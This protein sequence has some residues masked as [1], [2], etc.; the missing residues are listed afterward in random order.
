[1]RKAALLLFMVLFP[2]M[3]AEVCAQN[4][5]YD[6]NGDGIVDNEDVVCLVNKILGIADGTDDSG[7]SYDV[8]KDQKIDMVDVTTVIA[9]LSDSA[10]SEVCVLNEGIGDWSQMRVSNKGGLVAVKFQNETV[11][12]PNQVALLIPNSNGGTSHVAFLNFQDDGTLRSVLVDENMI[13]IHSS[14]DGMMDVTVVLGDTLALCY[15]RIP[16]SSAMAR[17]LSL[18]RRAWGENNWVSNVHGALDMILGVAETLLGG[19]IVNTSVVFSG[20]GGAGLGINTG[21]ATIE[22]GLSNIKE[23]YNSL[24]VES[25][26]ESDFYFGERI[27]GKLKEK[28]IDVIGSDFIE[29]I[30]G[31]SRVANVVGWIDFV[32]DYANEKWGMTMTANDFDERIQGRVSTMPPTVHQESAIISAYIDPDLAVS[33]LNG[34]PLNCECGFAIFPANNK[35]SYKLYHLGECSGG[36][37]SV[38]AAGLTPG[39]RYAYRA[40]FKDIDHS[41]TAWSWDTRAFITLKVTTGD[42]KLKLDESFELNGSVI[43]TENAKREARIWF[44]YSAEN[45]DPH[46]GYSNCT[47]ILVTENAHDGDYSARLTDYNTDETYYYRIVL[48][49]DGVDNNGEVRTF[50]L[51]RFVGLTYEP[52]GSVSLSNRT[53][54]TQCKARTYFRPNELQSNPCVVLI[55]NGKVVARYGLTME[56]AGNDVDLYSCEI[57][58]G[59]EESDL[60]IDFQ[61]YKARTKD[62]YLAPCYDMMI[63]G[64]MQT[65]VFDE[66]QVKFDITY[67]EEPEIL[68]LSA[69]VPNTPEITVGS[70]GKCVAKTTY[71]S[72]IGAV[73]AFWINNATYKGIS[74]S[75]S[76]IDLANDP[77]GTLMDGHIL[78]I[79]GV[80]NVVF[81]PD[82]LF[83]DLTLQNYIE[84]TLPY[85]EKKQSFNHLTFLNNGYYIT[86]VRIDV[87]N[88]S[89]SRQSTK[90]KSQAGGESQFP[91]ITI[92]N[93]VVS[94]ED[95]MRGIPEKWRN[96][97][98][99]STLKKQAA[100]RNY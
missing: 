61:N 82:K 92:E 15:D 45:K 86:D 16:K 17:Q 48:E 19:A 77:I 24:F 21:I 51:N 94:Q 25:G 38:E 73:G 50:G 8:N 43:G 76:W 46:L 29:N 13:S 26:Q 85:G 95:V 87:G 99:I 100:M 39:T 68:F 18:Q 97:P 62:L 35:N 69:E 56:E 60:N 71:I 98:T 74:S 9:V 36:T 7:Y 78:K 52:L 47:S 42:A 40:Y 31:I 6:V 79:S 81:D 70:D 75:D 58:V 28:M 53:I 4:G 27:I 3:S 54:I 59:L 96:V 55:Q 63:E 12:T 72:E 32:S 14:Y 65:L 30:E 90:S 5:V 88:V 80:I 91:R 84:I 64:Q 23:G 93:G 83:G 66:L 22:D 44:V 89:A 10:D 1:M 33:P 67:E 20:T 49:I 41:A 57:L 2:L 34:K 37:F 11:E